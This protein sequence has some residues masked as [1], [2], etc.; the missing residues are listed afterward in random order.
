MIFSVSLIRY[1]S[2]A[3][4]VF[5]NF[6]NWLSKIDEQVAGYFQHRLLL[7]GKITWFGLAGLYIR[8]VLWLMSKSQIAPY[9]SKD[10]FSDK[11]LQSKY[12]YN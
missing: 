6:E 3:M 1:A 10:N 11:S 2:Y 9:N 7:E 4:Y 12:Y 8:L 5:R